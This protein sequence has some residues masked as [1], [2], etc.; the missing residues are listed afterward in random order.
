MKRNGRAGEQFSVHIRLGSDELMTTIFSQQDSDHMLNALD[1]SR[2]DVDAMFISLCLSVIGHILML[3]QSWVLLGC[4][5][6]LDELTAKMK[7]EME[8]SD[9]QELPF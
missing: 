3:P 5:A 8:A 2:E 6:L 4:G 7:A 1:G 9:D